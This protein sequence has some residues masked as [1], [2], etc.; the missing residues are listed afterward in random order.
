MGGQRQDKDERIS[1]ALLDGLPSDPA[2]VDQ[3]RQR[4][5][6]LSPL[7]NLKVLRGD[8]LCVTSLAAFGLLQ[9]RK[10]KRKTPELMVYIQQGEQTRINN[11]LIAGNSGKHSENKYYFEKS[12]K[13]YLGGMKIMILIR[14]QFYLIPRTMFAQALTSRMPFVSSSC[15]Q[16]EKTTFVEKS[17]ENRTEQKNK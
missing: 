7:V 14:K 8:F 4:Y 2:R 6:D 12:I 15:R 1:G 11:A 3:G 5:S 9:W 16:R 13:I 10:K 17:S